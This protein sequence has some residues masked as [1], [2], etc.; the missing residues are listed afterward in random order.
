MGHAESTLHDQSVEQKRLSL[1][2]YW[3]PFTPNRDFKADPKMIVRAEGM[4]YWNDRGEKLIDASSGCS[5]APPGTAA[6]R[7]PR[8]S[9]A[10]S[11]SST[12]R[13]RSCAAIPS[14]SSS[15]RASPS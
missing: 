1:D 4:Y 2:E 15:R 12:S 9:A 8:R 6:R 5:A 10:S 14:S 11:R 3:M 7:S 13:R